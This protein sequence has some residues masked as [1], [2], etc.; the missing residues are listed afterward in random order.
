[1]LS[2][3]AMRFRKYLIICGLGLAGCSTS[4]NYTAAKVATEG[5]Q[6][7]MDN[8]EYTTIYDQ[9]DKRFK[10]AATLD[11]FSGFLKRIARKTGKCGTSVTSLGG[12][13]GWNSNGLVTINSDRNCENGKL[14]EQFYWSVV[15]G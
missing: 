5:L 15:N 13:K 3:Y 9:L 11:G 8:G 2:S 10:A 6:R 1:M 14:E 4:G 12:Y 7:L